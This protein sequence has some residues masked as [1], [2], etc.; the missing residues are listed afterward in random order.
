METYRFGSNFSYN[1]RHQPA[2]WNSTEHTL[3]Y[4]SKMA[5]APQQFCVRWNS[6]Q[7]N[8]Q[9]AFPKLLTSEHF[10]DVTLA[11]ENEMLKCH[12]VVLSACST[13]F[14]KLLLDNPCQHPIIFMKDMKWVFGW[15][16]LH[17]SLNLNCCQIYRNAVACGFHV[18]RGGERYTRWSTVVAEIGRGAT[19]SWFVRLWSAAGSSLLQQYQAAGHTVTTETEYTT[20]K[21]I[22]KNQ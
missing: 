15:I 20:T 13:Y 22:S 3:D 14:E 19:D 4:F 18:Q 17:F 12:K 11:C 7:T 2:P 8:L 6:Y 5:T 10:V 16:C 9:N 1:F 21:H